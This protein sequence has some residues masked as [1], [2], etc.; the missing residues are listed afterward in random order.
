MPAKSN[1]ERL[2]ADF[3]FLMTIPKS[4]AA[5]PPPDGAVFEVCRHVFGAPLVGHDPVIGDGVGTRAPHLALEDAR[6]ARGQTDGAFLLVV[7]VEQIEMARGTI[8]PRGQSA[9]QPT[10]DGLTERVE[11]K[12]EARTQRKCKFRHVRADEARWRL[13]P[14]GVT[15]RGDVLASDPRKPRIQF[16]S[17]NPAKRK[18]GREQYRA[19]HPGADIYKGEVLNR[20]GRAGPPPPLQDGMEDRRRH[21]E[22]R[23]GVAVVAMPGFE[24]PA[25]NQATGIHMIF[26][27]KRMGSVAIPG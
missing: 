23:G 17:N 15:P 1:V 8:H 16:D 27:I 25:R 5:C 22:V 24:M 13:C 26:K 19:P 4:P 7:D 18:L 9:Q 20:R 14:T 3:R 11:E 21:T 6:E 12:E 10:H 2:K